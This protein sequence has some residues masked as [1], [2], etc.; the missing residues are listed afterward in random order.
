[1][2]TKRLLRR[3]LVLLSLRWLPTGLLIPVLVLLLLDRGV[4]ISD[5]GLASATQGFVVMLLE[6]P[7]GALADSRGRRAVLI[8]AALFDLTSISLLLIAD[9]VALLIPVFALQGFFRALE[10]GPLDAWFVDS[11]QRIDPSAD[12]EQ[13]M[14]AAGAVLGVSLAAGTAGA[15]ILVAVDP[16][17]A[18]NPLVLPLLVSLALR[19]VHVVATAVLMVEEGETTVEPSSDR[20]GVVIREAV[21]IIGSSRGLRA[22]LAVELLWGAGMVAFESLTPVRLEAVTGSAA[23]AA[24]VFGPVT[25]VAWLASA[26]AAAAVPRLIRRLGATW[27]GALLRLVQGLTVAAIAV[28]A[29]VAGVVIA[30]LATMAVHGAAN[31]VHQGLLHRSVQGSR[32][33][34]T[35]LSANSLCGQLGGAVGVIALTALADRVSLGAAIVTGA[36]ILAAATPLYLLAGGHEK[37][38]GQR[39]QAMLA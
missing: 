6:L 23:A 10:S 25:A 32:N 19:L 33:R 4:S 36:V 8:A 20:V 11:A 16:V 37:D 29:G 5:I 7:T 12:I 2:T 15:G 21:Q 18:V 1:M 30:F 28:A 13:A 34:S 26:A 17:V 14:S 38:E 31:P 22:L 39:S 35:V 3:Y 27:T 9:S 24:A